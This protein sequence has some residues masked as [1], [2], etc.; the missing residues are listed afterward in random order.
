MK[1]HYEIPEMDM[2]HLGVKDTLTANVWEDGN[3]PTSEF[4]D[5]W[6]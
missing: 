6:E 3:A 2:I 1:K 5:D 4:I